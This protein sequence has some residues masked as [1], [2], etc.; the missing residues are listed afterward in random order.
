[1]NFLHELTQ[2]REFQDLFSVR[3]PLDLV[4][5]SF[6]I[7]ILY[8]VIGGTLSMIYNQIRYLT[9]A[10][11]TRTP[12]PLNVG[13]YTRTVLDGTATELVALRRSDDPIKQNSYINE[14]CRRLAYDTSP[15]AHSLVKQL[16]ARQRKLLTDVRW[17][18]AQKKFK[19]TA[20]ERLPRAVA[21]KGVMG[22]S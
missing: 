19:A 7:L 13:R 5:I 18:A 1:M 8:V 22:R 6:F 3:S 20:V 4:G 11:L 2:L 9:R 10:A 12:A 16:R 17:K 15:L 14:I 21:I